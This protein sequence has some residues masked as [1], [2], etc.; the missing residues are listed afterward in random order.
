VSAR[1]LDGII[2]RSALMFNVAQCDSTLFFGLSRRVRTASHTQKSIEPLARVASQYAATRS[3]SC[4]QFQ[5]LSTQQVGMRRWRNLIGLLTKIPTGTCPISL[6]Y[7]FREL[8]YG[9]GCRRRRSLLTMAVRLGRTQPTVERLGIQRG[10]QV[11]REYRALGYFSAS[12][13]K[14]RPSQPQVRP[15]IQSGG[16]ARTFISTSRSATRREKGFP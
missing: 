9:R 5:P 4:L 7:L 16:S 15:I 10:H 13:R 6:G 14:K 2:A 3:T 12:R 11:T 8:F 1:I